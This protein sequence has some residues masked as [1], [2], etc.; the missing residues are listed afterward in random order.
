MVYIA[1]T[2]ADGFFFDSMIPDAEVI[3]YLIVLVA[4]GSALVTTHRAE[5]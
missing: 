3:D 4:N 2:D 5:V 1:F